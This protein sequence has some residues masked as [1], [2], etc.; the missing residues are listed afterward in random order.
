M[1]TGAARRTERLMCLVFILKARGRRG[2]TKAELRSAVEDYADC[3]STDAFERMLERDKRD[4]RDAGVLV[5][6]V[7]RDAWHEDE[8][9]YVLGGETLLTLPSLGADELRMLSLAAESWERGAWDALAHGALRK[10]EV[11]ASEL[12]SV[13]RPRITWSIDGRLE[14]LR[15][16]IRERR[17]VRF[18]YRRPDDVEPLERNVEPWG[19]LARGG[20]WYCV[21]FDLDR[22]AARVFRISRIAG[23]V[24][25]RGNAVH[26]LDPAWRDIPTTAHFEG[27]RALLRIA[28]E[29]GWA[30]REA[31][32]AVG[33]EEVA[34]ARHDIVEVV[35]DDAAVGPLAAAA[36][37]VIVLEPA[38]LRARV[39]AHLEAVAHG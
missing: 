12:A 39:I 25:V 30:W 31:G 13:D 22:D 38:D 21:G 19:L 3:P 9:A 6:V 32:R 15:Q 11:F 23:T 36:P 7:Q 2:I 10:L 18:A 17:A 37:N 34:D 20:G 35:V 27:T 24:E 29:R 33:T 4:L 5:D 8:H 28:P 16:A 14:V 1:A 26:P